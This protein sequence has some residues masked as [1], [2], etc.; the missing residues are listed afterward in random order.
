MKKTIFPL[1][2]SFPILASSSN[3]LTSTTFAEIPIEG[4]DIE[5]PNA[6]IGTEIVFPGVDSICAYSGAPLTHFGVITG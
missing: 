4:V 6:A 5:P 2:E 3:D 1:I